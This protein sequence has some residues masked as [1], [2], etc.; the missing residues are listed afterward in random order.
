M[1]GLLKSLG[2]KD[3]ILLPVAKYFLNSIK[4]VK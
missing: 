4:Q 1:L 2:F 3:A